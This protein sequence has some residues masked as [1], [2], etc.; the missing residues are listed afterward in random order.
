MI[1]PLSLRT[2]KSPAS[3]TEMLAVLLAAL[4]IPIGWL[5]GWL[6]NRLV[7]QLIPGTL[8][9][10]LP[11]SP[12]SSRPTSPKT[13][14]AQRSPHTPTPTRLHRSRA[15]VD[16]QH[17]VLLALHR[18]IDRVESDAAN[19]ALRFLPGKQ[20]ELSEFRCRPRLLRRTGVDV[21]S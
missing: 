14:C 10:I 19:R 2:A 6:M 1:P 4:L 11:S 16:L 7:M 15:A 20:P 8:R 17:V 5:G 3:Q 18:R 13:R 9:V 21:N 12:T